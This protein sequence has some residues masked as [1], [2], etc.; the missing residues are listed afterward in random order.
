MM[1]ERSWKLERDVRKDGGEGGET[2]RWK[3]R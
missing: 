1:E 3:G 2:G